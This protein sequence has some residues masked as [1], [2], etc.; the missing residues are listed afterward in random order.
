MNANLYDETYFKDRER[1]ADATARKNFTALK[2]CMR[3]GATRFLDVGCGD[4]HL[5]RMLRR[6]GYNVVGIDIVPHDEPYTILGSAT[7]IPFKDQYFDVAIASDVLEHLTEEENIIAEREL[8]RV[9][10]QVFVRV[11]V[12]PEVGHYTLHP[13]QWWKEHYPHYTYL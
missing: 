5:V 2:T 1:Y 6:R 12:K 3:K 13:L 7:D 4:G 9:A 11:G 10:K 8:L